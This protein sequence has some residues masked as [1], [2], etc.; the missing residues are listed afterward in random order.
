L[1]TDDAVVPELFVGYT[2]TNAAEQQD[3]TFTNAEEQQ[4]NAL[5]HILL[6]IL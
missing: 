1:R 5:T 4:D 6:S 2:V 3:Y